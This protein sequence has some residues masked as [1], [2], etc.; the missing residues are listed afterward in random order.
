MHTSNA[1]LESCTL[2]FVAAINAHDPDAIVAR[3]SAKHAFVDSLGNSVTGIVR[4]R[5]AWQWYFGVFPDYRIEVDELLVGPTCALL[6]GS[7]SATHVTSGGNWSI[8]AAWKAKVVSGHMT[9]W[10]VYAD[11]KPVYEILARGV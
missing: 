6:T 3:C 10:Q 7:A 5:Q 8:P 9:H 11:N 2:A 4:L 1:D